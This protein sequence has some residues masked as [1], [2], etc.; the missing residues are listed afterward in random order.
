MT[1]TETQPKPF[2]LAQTFVSLGLLAFLISAGL[3]LHCLAENRAL[4]QWLMRTDQ[5]LKRKDLNRYSFENYFVDFEDRLINEEIPKD[6]YEKGGVYLFG[7]SNLK[8]AT[9]FW[10]L[11]ENERALVHNY[12]MGSANHGYQFQLLQYLVNH[13]NMLSAGGEKSMVIFGVSYHC[14][15]TVYDTNGFFPNVWLRHGL[16]DYDLATGITPKAANLLARQIHFDRVRIAGCLKNIASTMAH[17]AG[18]HSTPRRH[19]PEEY[20]RE[21]AEW[22]GLDWR[23]KIQNQVGELSRMVDYLIQRGVRVSIVFLPVGSWDD[24]L[25]FEREYIGVVTESIKGKPVQM[26]NWS[27]LL[28]DEDFADSNHPN[29]LGV[30]KLQKAFLDL[31]RPFLLSTGALSN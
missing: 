16:F 25:P 24:K 23:K 6:T 3:L 18:W 15:G 5:E 4:A 27:T 26:F 14:T 31:A 7:T 13:R 19:R 21:R 17:L 22:M 9:R 11:P 30:D 1:T 28:E 8:W 29:V 12:G 10:E 2:S 20:M